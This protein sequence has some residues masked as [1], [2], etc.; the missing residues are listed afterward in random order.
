MLATY[1]SENN[2]RNEYF[3]KKEKK[4][5]NVFYTLLRDSI[6]FSQDNVININKNDYEYLEEI[7]NYYLKVSKILEFYGIKS[8]SGE[9]YKNSPQATIYLVGGGIL[10]YQPDVNIL[11]NEDFIGFK[12]IRNDWYLLK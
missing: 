5:K 4:E 8:I 1:N 3:F 7:C 10:L 9:K 11:K 2:G 12:E 6:L